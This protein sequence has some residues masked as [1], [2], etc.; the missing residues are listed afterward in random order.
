VAVADGPLT[1]AQ[2]VG[3]QRI[4]TILKAR[5][6]EKW[7]R[8][9]GCLL[10]VTGDCTAVAGN[11]CNPVDRDSCE[12]PIVSTA[13]RLSPLFADSLRP[14]L[15]LSLCLPVSH[16]LS[17]AVLQKRE[18]VDGKYV[19]ARFSHRQK[20]GCCLLKVAPSSLL[21]RDANAPEDKVFHAASCPGACCPYSA[22]FFACCCS[23]WPC[24]F[25][26]HSFLCHADHFLCLADDVPRHGPSMSRSQGLPALRPCQVGCAPEARPGGAGRVQQIHPGDHLPAGHYNLPPPFFHQHALPTSQQQQHHLST[27]QTASASAGEQP[28]VGLCPPYEVGSTRRRT[29][30]RAAHTRTFPCKISTWQT[31]EGDPLITVFAPE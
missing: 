24:L 2:T 27:L 12:Q 8:V 25:L 15:V 26:P 21:V 1:N 28:D 20:D 22:V 6:A 17:L 30:Q 3:P 13:L 10:T 18:Q 31:G 7:R 14:M 19:C 16:P 29:T 5:T 23:H 11:F 9:G 4:A